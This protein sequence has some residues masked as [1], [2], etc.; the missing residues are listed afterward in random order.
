MD[1][2]TRQLVEW[3][4]RNSFAEPLSGLLPGGPYIN[5]NVHSLLDE[6]CAIF[7]YTQDEVGSV[8]NLVREKIEAKVNDSDGGEGGK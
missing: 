7:N 4:A 5:V 6:I 2:K 3:V 8:F 1:D